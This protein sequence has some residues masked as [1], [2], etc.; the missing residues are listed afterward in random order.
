METLLLLRDVWVLLIL[1][2]LPISALL[3]LPLL[4]REPAGWQLSF[5]TGLAWATVGGFLLELL[6]RFLFT[7]G[8]PWLHSIYGLLTALILYGVSGLREGG[9]LRDSLQKVPERIGPYFFW[10]SFVGTLLWWRFIQTGR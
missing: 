6:I 8:S 3:S 7:R 2:I 5:F 10:A 1:V 9:W 4:L